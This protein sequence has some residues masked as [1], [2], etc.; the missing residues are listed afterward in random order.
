MAT[1]RLVARGR[2][3]HRICEPEQGGGRVELGCLGTTLCDFHAGWREREG[4]RLGSRRKSR[5]MGKVGGNH[6]GRLLCTGA[7]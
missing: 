5:Y 3:H 1:P 4:D 6:W 7:I 2:L